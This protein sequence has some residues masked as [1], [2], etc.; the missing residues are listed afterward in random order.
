[1]DIFLLKSKPVKSPT[2]STSYI[3]PFSAPIHA[4]SIQPVRTLCVMSVFAAVCASPVLSVLPYYNEHQGFLDGFPG[5]KY[6]EIN[7]SK[8]MVK[9]PHD[10]T[11]TLQQAKFPEETPD[12]TKRVKYPGNFMLT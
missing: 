9:F 1:M 8:I 12:T 6:G 2:L 5:T 3:T 4:S 11:L 10:V 7:P